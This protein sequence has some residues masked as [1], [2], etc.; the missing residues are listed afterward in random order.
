MP[1]GGD[2]GVDLLCSRRRKS[3]SPGPPARSACEMAGLRKRIVGVA[4]FPLQVTLDFPGW[5]AGVETIAR[6]FS[7]RCAGRAAGLA[8]VTSYRAGNLIPTGSDISTWAMMFP[9]CAPPARFP[10]GFFPT[11]KKIVAFSRVMCIR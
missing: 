9:A 2:G 8:T 6:I 10:G 4:R 5:R 1:D 7:I 3:P 11:E